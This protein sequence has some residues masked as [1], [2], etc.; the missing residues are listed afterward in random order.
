MASMLFSD[1]VI[2]STRQVF[3]WPGRVEASAVA[4]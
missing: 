4:E 3:S 2:A 1:Q